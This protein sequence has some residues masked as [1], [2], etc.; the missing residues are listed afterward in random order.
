MIDTVI[1]DIGRVL[2][3]FCWKEYVHSFGYSEIIEGRVSYAVFQSGVWE[4]YDKGILPDEE[5]VSQMIE[6]AP[7]YEK[8]IREVT[9]NFEGCVKAFPYAENWIQNLNKQGIQTYYLSN[10]GEKMRKDTAQELKAISYCK[11]GVFS[12]EVK[13]IKPDAAI[14]QVLVDKYRLIPENCVFIDDVEKNVEAARKMG[15][16]GIVFRGYE[17]TC[18]E[19]TELL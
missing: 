15:M 11:G 18:R 1:F 14:Y 6:K 19:L 13:L 16:Q 9:T 10:Y 7:E 3:D 8:E 5:I 4:E 2:A 12:Y 17:E